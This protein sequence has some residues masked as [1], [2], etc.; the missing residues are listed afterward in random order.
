MYS[1]QTSVQIGQASFEIRNKG[2]FRMVLDCFEALNDEE[3]TPQEQMY[4]AL[5]IFYE[6]LNSL[7]DLLEQ[8]DLIPELYKEMVKFFN[9]GEEEIQS[10]TEGYK[11]IDW[12][13]DSNLLC[14]AINNVAKTEIRALKYLHWWT[15]LGYYT[16]MG[17]CTLS[18]IISIRYKIA[19]NEKLEKHEQKFR[20]SNPEYFNLDLRT[21]SQREAD[22]YIKQL[23]GGD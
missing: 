14:S 13:K 7:E 15:F 19:K 2:D 1:L 22:D 11:L 8:G 23:W 21:A 20:A 6:G 12:K 4:S 9:G 10:N 5:I 17:E 3:L 18:T 16:A